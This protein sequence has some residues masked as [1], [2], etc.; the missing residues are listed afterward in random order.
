MKRE[1]SVEVHRVSPPQILKSKVAEAK[2]GKKS[3]NAF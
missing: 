1:T 2:L 3:G